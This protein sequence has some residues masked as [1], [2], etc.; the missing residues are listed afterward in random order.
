MIV[1]YVG[2]GIRMAVA[3]ERERRYEDEGMGGCY[4]FRLGADLVVDATGVGNVARCVGCFLRMS[5]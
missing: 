1:E 5:L 4:M 2:E 3:D